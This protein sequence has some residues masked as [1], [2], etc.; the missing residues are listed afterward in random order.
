MNVFV[1]VNV[2]T[3]VLIFNKC[4]PMLTAFVVHSNRCSV[5]G[6]KVES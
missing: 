1:S 6:L 3:A 5:S 4:F 2:V